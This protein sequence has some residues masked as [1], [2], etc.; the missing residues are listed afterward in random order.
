MAPD[1]GKTIDLFYCVREEAEALYLNETR[2]VAVRVCGVRLHLLTSETGGRLAADGIAGAVSDLIT[3]NYYFF[4]PKP[5]L[6]A[7]TKGL[8]G[9]GVTPSQFHFEEFEMR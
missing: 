6:A 4:G 7:L 8:Q 3:R 2:K 9:K 5:M 1:H